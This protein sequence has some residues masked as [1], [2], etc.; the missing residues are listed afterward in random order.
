MIF[1]HARWLLV[2][3][4]VVGGA[5]VA[6]T[7]HLV[8]WMRGY[9]RGHFGRHRAV[10]RFSLI[11]LAL[12]FASFALG[13]LMYPTFRVRARSAYL[14]NPA[15][16]AA[17]LDARAAAAHAA[18]PGRDRLEDAARTTA[19]VARWFDVKEHW[20]AIGLVL[21][22]ACALILRFWDPA[23]HGRAIAPWVFGL[24]LGAACTAWLAAIIGLVVTSY[25]SLGA[26]G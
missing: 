1:E 23:R 4:A 11:A 12:F 22:L 13:N 18:A 19:R 9:P 10:R 26:L 6:A 16:V 21:S 2:L 24:A 7:T 17:D 3:H 15:A 20:V 25:R 8:V 5:A 14:D